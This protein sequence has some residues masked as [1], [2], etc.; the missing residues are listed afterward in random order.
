MTKEGEEKW[1]GLGSAQPNFSSVW[2]TRLSGGAS[3]SV[4]CARLVSGESA[5]LRNRWRCTTI[6]HRTVRWC[7]VLSG[8]SFAWTHRSREWRK[9]TWLKFTGLS[10]GAP[11]CPMSQRSPAPTVGRAIFARHVVAPMV[12][13]AHRTVRCA[14]NSVRCANRSRGPTVG[15]SPYGNK[16]S[17]GHEQ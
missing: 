10:G 2:H 6:I 16:S 8:E 17:T 14:P 13:W 1:K 11:D 9:A 3:D 5:A 7:T 12:S 15:C 4:Q